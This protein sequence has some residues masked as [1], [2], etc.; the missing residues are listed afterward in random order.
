MRHGIKSA[1]TSATQVSVDGSNEFG[2]P[3]SLRQILPSARLTTSDDIVVTS[4][5][6][7]AEQA[8]RGDMIVYRIGKDD[9]AKLVAQAMARGAGVILTE[10]LLPCPVPQC[11]VGDIE[12]AMAAITANQLDRPDRKLLTIGVIGSA[13]K[14][15]TSLLLSTLLKSSGVRVGFQTDLGTHDGIVQS[16]APESLA[17]SASLIQWLGEAVDAGANAVVVE[18]SDDEARYGHYDSIEFDVLVVCG[19]AIGGNDFGPSGL[20]CALERLTDDGVVV[21]P[22]DDPRAMQIIEEHDIK[23]VTYGVRKAADLTAKIIDHADGMTTLLVTHH[24]TT[25]VMETSLCGGAMAANHAAAVL[26]GLLLD[27]PLHEAV[28]KVSSLRSVPG[29]GQRLS[30]FGQASVV[31]DLGGTVDRVAASLRTFR[32]MKGAGRLWCVL[33]ID[34]GEQPEILA[35]Y[36]HLIERFADNCVVTSD[37]ATRQSFL[38]A[39]HAV[40]DGVEQCVAM[41][42]VADRDRAIQWAMSEAG[43]NDTILVITGQRHQTPLAARTELGELEKLVE[44]AWTKSEDNDPKPKLKIFG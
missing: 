44:T 29:R 9:P 12:L 35:R 19:S 25:A 38:P 32:S 34:G 24:D 40:L 6:P 3:L 36:G 15:T 33:A 39:S 21:S 16:T 43:I 28:E 22:A 30:R 8:V 7:S 5:A 13:G 11:I 27:Q 18:L 2:S 20:Q 1:R 14:T 17:S 10:Q 37:P 23:H 26:V 42:L 4:I 31:L 41:R